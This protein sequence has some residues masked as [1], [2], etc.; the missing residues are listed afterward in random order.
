MNRLSLRV[1]LLVILAIALSP[2]LVIGGVQWATSAA[3]EDDRRQTIMFLVA[4][5]AADRAD[6]VLSTGPA[7]LELLDSLIARE[8]CTPELD[9]LLGLFRQFSNYAVSDETGRVQCSLYPAAPGATFAGA[10]WFERMREGEGPELVTFSYFNEEQ[11]R[12]TLVMAR[13]YQR[14]QGGFGGALTVGLP[15]SALAYSFDRS[16]LPPGSEVALVNMPG[17]VMSSRYW[18][19]LEPGLAE[20]LRPGERAFFRQSTADGGVREVA[21]A[22]LRTVDMFAMLSAPPRP[23]LA[24]ENISAFG[25]FALPLLAW[26]LALVTAWLAA[27]RLVLRWLDYLRRIAHLYASGKLSVQPIRAKQQAPNEV[28]VLA[29]TLEHMA[30]QISDR[31]TRLEAA[32]EARDAAMKEI[33]HRVKNNLQIINSLLSLQSR[34]IDDPAALAALDDAR[35]RISA[36]SLI[37]RSLYEHP[38]VR[39]VQ[40]RPFLEELSAYLDQA[41]GSD[42]Q[43]IHLACRADDDEIETDQAVP[44][45]LFA[46]EAVTNA[47]KH[48]FPASRGGVVTIDY[49]VKDDTAVLSVIDDGVGGERETSAGLGAQ[50]MAAFAKQL[51]GTMQE[52][53]G[54]RGG[55]TVTLTFPRRWAGAG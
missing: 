10:P 46:V 34:K 15:F 22:P 14:P 33:H 27:D 20:Q 18:S 2:V 44:I 39:K 38:D 13:P 9:R 29:D 7:L 51:R 30:V 17:G 43:A 4:E 55:R 19:E 49:A 16:G 48:A 50:L 35:G 11:Q 37:H 24:L 40:I 26:V 23:P 3:R 31:T 1:M 54:D 52:T 42:E 8:G 21:L 32:V 36:L 12:W 5:E 53:R 25:S 45:A 6:L 41:L 28:M 47:F